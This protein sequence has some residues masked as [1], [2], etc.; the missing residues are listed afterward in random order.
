MSLRLS[1]WTLLILLFVSSTGTFGERIKF[2]RKKFDRSRFDRAGTT[3]APAPAPTP[4]PV[5]VEE[6]APTAEPTGSS[7]WQGGSEP[8]GGSSWKSGAN[9]SGGSSW[10]T[11]APVSTNQADG[12][13]SANATLP[14]GPPPPKFWPGATAEEIAAY[15]SPL[16][17]EVPG[18]TF[19][20]AKQFEELQALQKKT[21]ACLI[22]YFK[23][24]TVPNQKGLCNWYEKTVTKNMKWRK[25]M[26]HYIKLEITQPGT[27]V[28]KALTE[29]MRANSSPNVTILHPGSPR[30]TRLKLFE[31]G[32][33]SRPEPI[34]AENVLQQLKE[35]STPAYG[36]LF[37]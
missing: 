32:P 15:H 17:D 36:A 18:K 20:K 21:G 5:V 10:Q 8:T 9:S 23:N 22:I 34:E 3:A 31:F 19:K 14:D 12:I 11:G 29:Q 33:N 2:Q 28:T 13:F 25:A 7:S 37:D 24:P 6:E 30:G 1:L 26:R 27:K 4:A 35:A 16:W